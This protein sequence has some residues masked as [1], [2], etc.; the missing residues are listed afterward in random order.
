ME[1]A[2]DANIDDPFVICTRCPDDKLTPAPAPV[3]I[4]M[5]FSDVPPLAPDEET[6]TTVEQPAVTQKETMKKGPSLIG[7]LYFDFDSSKIR[8]NEK[9]TLNGVGQ[10]QYRLKGYT[11]IIGTDKYNLGLSKR[12]AETVAGFLKKNGIHII[13]VQGMG[14]SS[15]NM[16]KKLNR[17]VDIYRSEE[18][19][20][21]EDKN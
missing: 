17:R 4:S 12:R 15:E 16:D 2:K 8:P 1:I 18:S 11:C 6:K 19:D 9:R 14:K 5:L 21:H 3:Q 13:E 20:K 7:R 10:G